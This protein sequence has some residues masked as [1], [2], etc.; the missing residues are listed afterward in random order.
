MLT[1]TSF[2][3]VPNSMCG[4]RNPQATDHGSPNDGNF[5]NN[6]RGYNICNRQKNRNS[7]F[8][9]RGSNDNRDNNGF[10]DGENHNHVENNDNVVRHYYRETNDHPNAQSNQAVCHRSK[11][12]GVCTSCRIVG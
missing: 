6:D 8:D 2:Y 7:A 1:A 4:K 12:S 3:I 5:S 9:V 10:D 11:T